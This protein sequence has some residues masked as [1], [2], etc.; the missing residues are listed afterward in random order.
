MSFQANDGLAPLNIPDY[1][2]SNPYVLIIMRK[3]R[4]HSVY[5]ISSDEGAL[6]RTL[7]ENNIWIY[8]AESS[9]RLQKIS[10]SEAL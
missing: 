1:S 10:N 3:F 5:K 6:N 4:A 2:V 8:K 9:R 7:S